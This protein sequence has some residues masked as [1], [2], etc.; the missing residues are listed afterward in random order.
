ML[1]DES[2]SDSETGRFKCQSKPKEE[3]NSKQRDGNFKR[4]GRPS[5]NGRFRRDFGRERDEYDKHSRDRHRNPRTSPLNRTRNSRD[6]SPRRRSPE[7]HRDRDSSAKF[8]HHRGSSKE[9][10]NFTSKSHKSPDRPRTSKSPE[11]KA[12]MQKSPESRSRAHKSPEIRTR[13]RSPEPRSRSHKSPEPKRDMKEETRHQTR[14]SPPKSRESQD[15]VSLS[16]DFRGKRSEVYRPPPSAPSKRKSDS[17]ITVEEQESDKSEEV[18]VG[19][20][21]KMIPTVVKE[22][23]EE[24]SEIDSSDDERLR[25][26]L[27]NL[28]KELQKTKK[29]KHKKKH[30]RKNK[31]S[32]ERD[33]AAPAVE[34]TSSTDI[35]VKDGSSNKNS[36]VPEVSSTQKTAS[37][38]SSEEGEISSGDDT[39]DSQEQFD[40]SDLRHKLSRKPGTSIADVC[41]PMLPP[42]L[43]KKRSS[44][45]REG[46]A[47]PPHLS[48]SKN[49]GQYFQIQYILYLTHALFVS[50]E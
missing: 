46:P 26:K 1:S 2:S 13:V 30:K 3:Q 33:E 4:R 31:S 25:A 17:P 49:I 11:L 19:S 5:D 32:K 36:P 9:K 22:K 27:L 43:E 28:E 35:D 45:D 44:I 21:Y 6:R 12:K 47:L 8:R 41:G 18:Q 40:A 29:K 37:K 15:R 38:E 7:R 48:K 39:Q 20:Y 14:K 42:H 24:S 34:V 16:P 10:R 23:Q 50:T